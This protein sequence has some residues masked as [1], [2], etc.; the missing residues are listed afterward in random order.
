MPI[1]LF[2][3]LIDVMGKAA[4]SLKLLADLP[5]A[6]RDSIRQT[7]DE[8]YRLLDTTLNM[9]IIRLGDIALQSSDADFLQEVAKLD[10]WNEWMQA[11]REFRLCRSLRVAVRETETL[12]R[13]LA[14]RVS[15]KDWDSLIQLMQA[16]LV[17]EGEVALTIVN[18]FTTL[19]D[20]ARI[21]LSANQPAAPLR[22]SVREFR[23]ALIAERQQLLK[24]ELQLYDE[25]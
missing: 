16:V 5:K 23:A 18:Q 8:T 21:A 20:N 12:G 9:V 3:D 10:N 13:Q 2:S 1:S 4:G 17:G 15:V 7:M 14:G 22:D 19:S 25:I 6:E 24:Q 11:E